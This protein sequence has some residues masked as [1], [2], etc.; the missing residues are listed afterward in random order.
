MPSWEAWRE[1]AGQVL[2]T[3]DPHSGSHGGGGQPGR[4][5][6]RVQHG[7]GQVFSYLR[8]ENWGG[9]QL[10]YIEVRQG[11]NFG[12]KIMLRKL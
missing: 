1:V 11:I 5:Q 10:Q 2:Q 6:H 8:E 9:V 12:V 3:G 4:K 7:Q